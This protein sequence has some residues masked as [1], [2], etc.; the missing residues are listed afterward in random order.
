[1]KNP[2]T[3]LDNVGSKLEVTRYTERLVPSTRFLPY[4][5]KSPSY[6]KAFVSPSA[7]LIGDVTIGENSSIW[8][9]A[10]LRGDV[11]SITVGRNTSI[12]D[13]ATIHVAKIQGDFNT[14]IGNQCVISAGAI[15]HAASL[16]SSVFV[17]EGAQVLDGAIVGDNVLI[18]CGAVISP[19]TNVPSGTV[20][21]GK[22]AKNVRVLSKEDMAYIGVK[23]A[24]NGIMAGIH[25][26]ECAKSQSMVEADVLLNDDL[27]SRDED[28]FQPDYDGTREDTL[29]VLGQGEAGMIW[30]STL[31]DPSAVLNK[32]TE[33]RIKDEEAIKKYEADGGEM[34]TK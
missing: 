23:V 22:P 4:G 9:N 24:E 28:Y 13:A 27:A 21:S 20:W 26:H 30:N 34:T 32:V 8:Y 14:Q 31:S 6:A 16:G 33:Q 1:M 29:D 18:E 15:I 7:T 25:S 12:G 11:N 5:G 3:I 19:G 10:V 2:R 17:G